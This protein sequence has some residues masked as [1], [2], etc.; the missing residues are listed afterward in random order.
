MTL[1]AER[2]PAVR[3]ETGDR[4]PATTARAPGKKRGFCQELAASAAGYVH[5]P[6]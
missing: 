3:Y 6:G 1:G 2:R 5:V 4:A